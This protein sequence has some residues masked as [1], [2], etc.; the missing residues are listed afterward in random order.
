MKPMRIDLRSE[1]VNQPAFAMKEAMLAAPLGDDVLGDDPTVNSF[2][3]R[4]VLYFDFEQAFF[5]LSETMTNQIALNTLTRAG[6]EVVCHKLSHIYRYE[7]GG[8]AVNSSLF[9]K[10]P[11]G[12]RGIVSVRQ[13]VENINADD[14]SFPKNKIGRFREHHGQGGRLLL[15]VGSPK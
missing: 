11:E 4:I 12:D 6:D 15:Q 8:M 3:Q 9:P 13:I 5:R 14:P 2:Q 7:G 10:L 1:T